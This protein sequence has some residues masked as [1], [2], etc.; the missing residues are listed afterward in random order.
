[1]QKFVADER[2][3][4]LVREKLQELFNRQGREGVR[5]ELARY[6]REVLEPSVA[7]LKED[8]LIRPQL[9]T[10]LAETEEVIDELKSAAGRL[11]LVR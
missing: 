11:S 1:M 3:V 2:M 6:C 7:E 5:E 10:E 9:E 8:D 4:A